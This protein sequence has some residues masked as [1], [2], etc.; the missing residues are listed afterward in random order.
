MLIY[1]AAVRLQWRPAPSSRARRQHSG[2]AGSTEGG[3]ATPET[4][5]PPPLSHTGRRHRT[6][7]VTGTTVPHGTICTCI[8]HTAFRA[9]TIQ[10]T[11]WSHTWNGRQ[12]KPAWHGAWQCAWHT[13]HGRNYSMASMA[14]Y[15]YCNPLHT[16]HIPQ[17][18][19][20]SKVSS[21]M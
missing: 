3:E 4:P 8:V 10:S 21:R 17:S 12:D 7:D 11:R 18:T 9:D 13:W 19:I 15:A 2:A 16:I 5:P 6:A 1:R 20:H 14:G